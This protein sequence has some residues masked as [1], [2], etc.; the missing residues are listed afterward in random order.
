MNSYNI[1]ETQF[2][3]LKIS[4]LSYNDSI[5]LKTILKRYIY[6]ELKKGPKYGRNIR[7]ILI[8]DNE[9][10]RYNMGI[11]RIF[12]TVDDEDSKIFI[13]TLDIRYY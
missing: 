1:F 10:W 3:S 7:K 11:F 5:K 4:R 2:F 9:F 6:P 12:Y 8:D 13:L